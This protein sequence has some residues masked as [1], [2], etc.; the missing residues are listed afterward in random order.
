MAATIIIPGKT[1]TKGQ[2][3][4]ECKDGYYVYRKDS[5]KPR[6]VSYGYTRKKTEKLAEW[7]REQ[8]TQWDNPLDSWYGDPKGYKYY[9][10]TMD[11]V[12]QVCQLLGVQC[13]ALAHKDLMGLEDCWIEIGGAKREVKIR[14]KYIIYHHLMAKGQLFGS[15]VMWDDIL[16]FK[17]LYEGY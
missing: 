5:N 10:D 1:T 3:T 11:K 16:E 9:L 6:E 8:G 2:V 15:R 7:L 12:E 14:G 13:Y 4:V 17:I